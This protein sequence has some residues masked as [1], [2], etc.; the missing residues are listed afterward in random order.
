MIVPT[1]MKL[2]NSSY[3]RV[4]L[5]L[6]FSCCPLGALARTFIYVTLGTLYKVI[7]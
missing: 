5:R 4:S 3:K 6:S 1:S 2:P 7:I